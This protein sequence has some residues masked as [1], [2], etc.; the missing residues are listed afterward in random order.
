M[1][2]HRPLSLLLTPLML[3]ACNAILQAYSFTGLGDL[4]GG[5][6]SSSAYGVSSN[7]AVVVGKVDSN[8]G[9]EAFRWTRSGGMVGLGD[10]GI[11]ELFPGN[12]FSGAAGVSG[13]GS[14]VAGTAHSLNGSEAF[15][16][17]EMDG[18]V[19]LGDIPEGINFVLGNA[20][21]ED[22]L[23]IV[24][25]ADTSETNQAF[26]WTSASGM[27]GLGFLDGGTPEDPTLS[28]S[29]ATGVSGDGSVVVG[30]S[31]SDAGIQAFRWTGSGGMVGLGDL[32]GGRFGSR[33]TA[34]SVDGQVVVGQ[35]TSLS[36]GFG[37]EAFRWTSAEGIVGLGTISGS[38]S[39]IAHG[40]SGNGSVVVGKSGVAF[41]WDSFN[42]MRDLRSVL[43][44]D[45]GLGSSLNGWS[46]SEANA[47]SVDGRA[48]VGF[49]INP[50]GDGEAWLVIIPEPSSLT[51]IAIGLS[52]LFG[53]GRQTGSKRG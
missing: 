2:N 37:D 11:G 16:W 20:I 12:G 3:C 33:A 19:G 1:T 31:F 22:G 23:V 9:R 15:R 50:S 14:V 26:R 27:V 5:R 21:S 43:V 8:F 25:D 13:D 17:T 32:P 44:N 53:C 47:V 36:T 52:G 18:M 40:V 6:T 41:I 10:L 28:F 4:P 51:L 46:L 24:G 34:V 38:S 7:G 39:S 35:G 42:G 45:F 48:I 29:G 30:R 49:G